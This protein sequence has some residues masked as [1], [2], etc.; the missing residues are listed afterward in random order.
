[1]SNKDMVRVRVRQSISEAPYPSS[2]AIVD[3]PRERALYWQKI[4]SVEILDRTGRVVKNTPLEKLLELR[5]KGLTLQEIAREVGISKSAVHKRLKKEGL[6]GRV[7]IVNRIR[8]LEKMVARLEDK[9]TR[10][11]EQERD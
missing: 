2:G 6:T 7:D 8:R 3:L 11:T 5:E 4:G 1:M 9:V 10:I